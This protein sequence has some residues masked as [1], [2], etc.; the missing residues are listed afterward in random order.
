MRRFPWISLAILSAL[1]LEAPASSA[2]ASGEELPK[3]AA[4]EHGKNEAGPDKTLK[5]KTYPHKSLRKSS[6][7]RGGQAYWLFEPTE[8]TPEK[9]PVVVFFH[10]WLATNPGVYGA[11]IDHLTRSGRIVIAPRYQKDWSTPP[12]RFLPN[13]LAAIH[14]ALDVLTTAEGRVRPDLTKFALLG[15][16]AGGNLAAQVAAVAELENLPEPKAVVCVTPGEVREGEGP[17]LD[18]IPKDTLLV[19]V[20]TEHDW[21]VGDQRA[22]QIFLLGNQIPASRKRFVLY[23]TDR[24]GWPPL[25]ADHVTPT[26]SLAELD[27]GEGPFHAF[28]I[29]K[30]QT[31]AHDRLGLWRLAE[32]TLEAADQGRTL[33]Q[34]THQN[35]LIL[36]LGHWSDGRPILQPVVA[37]DLS[38]IPRVLF[39]NGLRVYNR[40]NLA[41]PQKT[42]DHVQPSHL[43]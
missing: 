14:D 27:T 36:D 29:S 4:R 3:T 24:H 7:G 18:R 22:R 10:G 15:H 41:D 26:A 5:P 40:P 17:P 6:H 11:W 20:A 23:R 32:I 31:D 16:S 25:V 21:I 13:S 35:S 8:P 37:D 19:V 42:D 30:A 39:P 2:R 38:S 28:Q 12:E 1:A 43:P 34:A 9:A 33:D